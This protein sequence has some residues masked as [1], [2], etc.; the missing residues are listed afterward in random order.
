[1]VPLSESDGKYLLRATSWR[2]R[3][4]RKGGG[5]RRF[6]CIKA[7]KALARSLKNGKDGRMDG[8]GKENKGNFL[9]NASKR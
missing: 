4:K 5:I 6:C 7:A 8:A 3:L 9:V 2:A 1:M